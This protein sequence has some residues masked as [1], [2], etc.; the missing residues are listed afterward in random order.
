MEKN[1]ELNIIVVGDSASGKT[2]IVKLF[3]K[4]LKMFDIEANIIGNYDDD[5]VKVNSNR[6]IEAIKGIKDKTFVT[7]QERQANSLNPPKC[8]KEEKSVSES[9]KYD[10]GDVVIV[11][12]NKTHE[13]S[14]NRCTVEMTSLNGQK[15]TITKKYPHGH[16]RIK[17]D[18]G[19][20]FWNDDMFLRKVGA[21]KYVWNGDDYDKGR[22]VD[23]V[24]YCSDLEYPYLVKHYK[25]DNQ[26]IG[27]EH[28][29]DI[30]ETKE[31]LSVSKS[32]VAKLLGMN[33]N[34]FEI[35]E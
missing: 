12:Q 14:K 10:V 8:K 7:I 17:E 16:Y 23:V 3:H 33:V 18:K 22:V 26:Y 25:K 34:D 6:M 13:R 35:I 24:G 9:A 20:Y 2:T 5:L 32:K 28:A 31:K 27:F 4:F 1:R 15:V 21:E 30:N 19:R 11:R 29:E